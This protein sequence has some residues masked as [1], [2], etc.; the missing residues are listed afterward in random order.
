VKSHGASAAVEKSGGREEIVVRDAEQRVIVTYCPE[1]GRT[2]LSVPAGDLVLSAPRGNIE[3]SSGGEVRCSGERLRL[4]ASSEGRE[5]TLSLDPKEARL[6]SGRLEMAAEKARLLFADTV[7]QGLTLSATLE[8]T[9]TVA[10]RMESVASEIVQRARRVFR[11][12]EQVE[13]VRAGRMRTV[14]DGAY[15]VEGGRAAILAEDDVKI[16]GK[17]VYLG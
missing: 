1:T 11:R 4:Q 13:E 7:F 14:V 8:R 5:T 2:V 12:V 16:D 9:R 17:R 6:S 10:A 15:S 3:L